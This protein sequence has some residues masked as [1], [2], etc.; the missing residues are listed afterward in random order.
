MSREQLVKYF[1]DIEFLVDI[2]YQLSSMH[3]DDLYL[4]LDTLLPEGTDINMA[5]KEVTEWK[6]QN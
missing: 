2:D 5:V 3:P 4:V 6:E 1:V